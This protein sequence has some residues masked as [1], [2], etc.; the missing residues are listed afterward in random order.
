MPVGAFIA[1]FGADFFGPR[2]VTILLAGL[3]GVIA[4]MV[5][6]KAPVVREYRLSTAI[7]GVD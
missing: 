7:T 6:F 1:G 4:V 3:A 5:F 2:M